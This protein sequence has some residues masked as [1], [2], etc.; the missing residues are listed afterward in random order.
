MKARQVFDGE[1]IEFLEGEPQTIICCDCGLAHDITLV[2]PA[3]EGT[4]A[5]PKTGY[6]RWGLNNRSTAQT[7]RFNKYKR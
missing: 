3:S 5:P 6:L 1:V 4:E 2:R 7:R